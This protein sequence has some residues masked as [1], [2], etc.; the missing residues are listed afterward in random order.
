MLINNI[1]VEN[2]G[3]RLTATEPKP[4][5]CMPHLNI[6]SK[7]YISALEHRLLPPANFPEGWNMGFCCVP[8]FWKAGT[9]TFAVFFL[10]GCLAGCWLA[11]C[12]LAGWVKKVLFSKA[13]PISQDMRQT[14][15]PHP[16]PTHTP[17][18]HPSSH[19]DRLS[20]TQNLTR[21][22]KAAPPRACQS[23]P[24]LPPPTHLRPF[25]CVRR[26]LWNRKT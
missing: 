3:C 25:F 11:G 24:R 5:S 17:L 26:L 13:R 6:T 20:Q 23:T 15:A 8:A 18:P 22:R 1:S 12:S 9:T 10:A 2:R 7:L 19:L 14:R 16:T 21:E 4:R